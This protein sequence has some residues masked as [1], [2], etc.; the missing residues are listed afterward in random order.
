MS[1]N[2]PSTI[3]LFPLRG[4]LLLPRGQLPLNIFEDRYLKMI[5]DA[6]STHRIIGMIQPRDKG[7]GYGADTDETDI[8]ELYNTGCAGR[9]TAFEETTDGRYLVTLTGLSRFDMAGE[10]VS[11]D[12]PYKV[13]SVDWGKYGHDFNNQ[14]CLNMDRQK[15]KDMLGD[16]FEIK[17][18]ECTT[19]IIDEASDD[20]IVTCLSMICPFDP[21]EKQALL[22]AECCK[23]RA[24]IFT[25]ML[26]MTI[27]GCHAEDGCKH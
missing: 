12:L 23:D 10:D 11:A 25:T 9:I 16:Y 14:T 27:R 7:E 17:G 1:N 20:K 24:R 4:A 22:E 26:E 3:P 13:A 5:D 21:C 19:D 15:L 6:L 8:G 18:I 2:L